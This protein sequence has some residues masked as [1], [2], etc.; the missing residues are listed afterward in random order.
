MRGIILETLETL[1]QAGKAIAQAHTNR[2]E[3]G[4]LHSAEADGEPF[5][6][7]FHEKSQGKEVMP[8][9]KKVGRQK[10]LRVHHAG[11]P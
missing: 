6:L 1:A 4:T 10:G 5:C 2:I 8:V 9:Y 3:G 7:G 11:I